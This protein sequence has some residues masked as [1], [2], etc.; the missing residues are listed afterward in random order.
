LHFVL[1]LSVL[2]C[3][4]NQNN[5]DSILSHAHIPPPILYVQ[6]IPILLQL[7]EKKLNTQKQEISDLMIT[8]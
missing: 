7:Q 4:S 1:D 5:L 3:S 2:V 6:Q 8:G